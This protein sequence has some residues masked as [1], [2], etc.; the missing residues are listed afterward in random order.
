MPAGQILL[1]A[2]KPNPGGGIIR[3]P[4]YTR[5]RSGDDKIRIIIDPDLAEE[6]AD[7]DKPASKKP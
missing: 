4:S 5:P 6:V 7:L 1:L 2:Y 3:Y